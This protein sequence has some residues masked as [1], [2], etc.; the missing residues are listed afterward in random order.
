M[1]PTTTALSIKLKIGSFRDNRV[2]SRNLKRSEISRTLLILFYL[3]FDLPAIFS[4]R[5]FNRSLSS[6]RKVVD[7]L[8]GEE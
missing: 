1:F 7:S 8:A 5:F 6:L 2:V 4:H 3:T